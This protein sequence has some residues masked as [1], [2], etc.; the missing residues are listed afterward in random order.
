LSLADAVK[1]AA[2]CGDVAFKDVQALIVDHKE[3]EDVV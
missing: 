1:A 3:S 2:I